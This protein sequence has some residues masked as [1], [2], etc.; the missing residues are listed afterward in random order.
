LCWYKNILERFFLF[1]TKDEN[2][3]KTNY[4]TLRRRR[5]VK[6][7][8]SSVYRILWFENSLIKKSW[9]RSC[10]FSY[11][12]VILRKWFFLS[13][14]W[15]SNVLRVWIALII[16]WC[17]FIE[18]F[19]Q[20]RRRFEFVS[21]QSKNVNFFLRR[22]DLYYVDEAFVKSRRFVDRILI[23][24]FFVNDRWQSEKTIRNFIEIQIH[25]RR[26]FLFICKR[27]SLDNLQDLCEQN[28]RRKF[29]FSFFRILLHVCVTRRF[30]VQ[31]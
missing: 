27:H 20:T 16:V 12:I 29:I 10:C 18:W 28:N 7:S 31:N 21:K 13:F 23:A 15:V 17:R 30:D 6:V 25:Q 14:F 9:F 19:F 8:E 11:C 26:F 4:T 24:A 1:H 3:W 5:Y 2:R 22:I